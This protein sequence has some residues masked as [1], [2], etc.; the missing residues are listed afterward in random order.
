MNI[1]VFSRYGDAGRELTVFRL[2]GVTDVHQVDRIDLQILDEVHFFVMSE[3]LQL[4]RM[5]LV[6]RGGHFI[7]E[8][9]IIS[10]LPMLL[11]DGEQFVHS[12]D[13]PVRLPCVVR[14]ANELEQFS[15]LFA[16]LDNLP[17]RKYD[18]QFAT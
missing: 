2:V 3:S 6:E 14:P 11:H 9:L 13:Q 18:V 10:I 1:I 8:G 7:L 15:G 17:A 5:I 12:I 4:P 16:L